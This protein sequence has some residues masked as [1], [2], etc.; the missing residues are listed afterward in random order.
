MAFENFPAADQYQYQPPT[1]KPHDWRNYLLTILSIALLGTWGYI[2]WKMNQTKETI[3]QKEAVIAT[4]TSAKD[5]VQNELNEALARYDQIKTQTAHMLHSKDSV[6]SSKARDIMAKQERIK[7][8]LAKAGDDKQKI[9]E[10][11]Q[12]IAELNGDI[13]NY[14]TKIET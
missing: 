13:E 8:M 9:A 4:T 5:E 2:I 1:K 14:K 3:Q 10:A 12:L 6:I 7:E 11:R